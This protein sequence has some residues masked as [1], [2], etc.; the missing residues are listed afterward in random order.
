MC[1]GRRL[2]HKWF[3][4]QS[5][6]VRAA[7]SEPGRECRGFLTQHYHPQAWAVAELQPKSKPA[8]L[9]CKLNEKCS[10]SVETVRS[11]GPTTETVELRK[12]S[13]KIADKSTS[14]GQLCPH[15]PKL[16]LS[17]A[18]SF[19]CEASLGPLACLHTPNIHLVNPLFPSPV[20]F[21][22]QPGSD[23]TEEPDNREVHHLSV[24]QELWQSLCAVDHCRVVAV[25]LPA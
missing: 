12:R 18:C 5:D 24:C 2:S 15:P 1:N 25:Q 22:K 6:C 11:R 3:W 20:C 13:L 17:P 19:Q 10:S 21:E 23:S 9:G 14:E 8:K 16:L 4:S 7:L